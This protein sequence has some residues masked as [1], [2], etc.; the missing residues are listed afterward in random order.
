MSQRLASTCSLAVL[1]VLCAAGLGCRSVNRTQTPCDD[2]PRRDSSG[3]DQ[4]QQALPVGDHQ[5]QQSPIQQASH[6]LTDA[7]IPG[8]PSADPIVHGYD[9]PAQMA[10]E[11]VPVGE[12]PSMGNALPEG[13]SIGGSQL[14]DRQVTA[15]E[16]ALRYKKDNER[17]KASQEAILADNQRL[18]NQ[19]QS[20]EQLLDRV[21][22]AMI[23]AREQMENAER[24]NNQ[25]KQRIIEM[26]REKKRSQFDTDRMLDAIRGELDDVLMREMAMDGK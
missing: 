11:L 13:P 19:L 21:K 7:A 20:T 2:I 15:T 5:S 12:L 26:E 4:N 1:V 8:V 6:P 10:T 16:H 22:A 24:A 17:L 3:S 18:R 23:D 14:S 25:L 9:D